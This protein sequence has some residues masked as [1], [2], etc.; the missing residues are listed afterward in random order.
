MRRSGEV[1]A[2]GFAHCFDLVPGACEA[3]EG[4][5]EFEEVGFDDGGGVAVGV[6]GDKDGGKDFPAFGF[7]DVDHFGHLVELVRA[8]VGAVGE[9]EIYLFGRMMDVSS[10]TLLPCSGTRLRWFRGPCYSSVEV[11]FSAYQCEF[12]FYICTRKPLAVL[13]DQV[14]V[15]SYP[16]PPDSF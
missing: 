1:D 10:C 3:D 5:V 13:I 14:K 11:E 9:A 4:G 15:S 7:D 16:R 8:D 2:V 6:A 12:P